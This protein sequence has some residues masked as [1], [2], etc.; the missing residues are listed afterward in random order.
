MMLSSK[1]FDSDNTL[2]HVGVVAYKLELPPQSPVHDVFH[3]S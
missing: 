1:L 3:I 2:D